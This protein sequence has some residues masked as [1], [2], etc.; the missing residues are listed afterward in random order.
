M[1]EDPQEW[2]DREEA[3]STSWGAPTWTCEDEPAQETEKGKP[4]TEE[5]N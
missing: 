3:K 1:V 2:G 4:V 5:E